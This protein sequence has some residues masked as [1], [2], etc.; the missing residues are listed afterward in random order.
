[1]IDYSK[2]SKEE[3]DKAFEELENQVPDPE[4]QKRQEQEQAKVNEAFKRG[5]YEKKGGDVVYKEDGRASF[6]LEKNKRA[7]I[8]SSIIK[9]EKKHGH[10]FWY[11][12]EIIMVFN[13]KPYE[14]TVKGLQ[15]YLDKK[16][17]FEKLTKKGLTSVECPTKIAE[18]LYNE[19]ETLLN[20]IKNFSFIP[21]F[22]PTTGDIL[23][24]EGYNERTRIF[25][26][27]AEDYPDISESPGMGEV[28]EAVSYLWK[29][30]EDFPFEDAQSKGAFFQS[31]L[32]IPV[33]PFL[34]TAPG[35]LITAPCAGSG[36][37]L[38]AQCVGT[39]S[40]QKAHIIPPSDAK[41]D[42]DEEMRKTLLALSL[43]GSNPVIFDNFTGHL[44]SNSL[45]VYLTSEEYDGRVLGASK[46]KSTNSQRSV[47]ITGNNVTLQG[48]LC[49][50]V[51]VTRLMPKTEK[52]WTRIFNTNPLEYCQSHMVE[53]ISEILTI[54][55]AHYNTQFRATTRTGSFEDWSDYVRS[56][57]IWLSEE[58]LFDAIDPEKSIDISYDDDPETQKLK[59]F[60][61]ITFAV[62]G[63]EKW[64]V[65]KLIKK[66]EDKDLT[67]LGEI[68]EM[69]EGER[70]EKTSLEWLRSSLEEIALSGKEINT[71]ILGRWLMKNQNRII[72][73][74]K[75]EK[76]NMRDGLQQWTIEK[77]EN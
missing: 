42:Q 72:D 8:V 41:K 32:S 46:M 47:F 77:V 58:G 28:R 52:P 5:D 54:L 4:Y 56:C 51:L 76:K 40:G 55:K 60:L 61:Q 1:M 33:R 73:G 74:L 18:G 66:S 35:L 65:K 36:K 57:V 45:C 15:Y 2:M 34:K 27:I 26:K 7:K 64:T 69:L 21:L 3:L 6:V 44:E 12:E 70:G 59:N 63:S 10:L 25:F 43:R 67:A 71:R 29:P 16:Y 68:R 23:I 14:T 22:I 13:G 75:I 19:R 53:M 30:F 11:N 62:F 49:R 50:R 37:T 38:L 39:L 17:I 9:E 24:D 31:L 20:E 48:D